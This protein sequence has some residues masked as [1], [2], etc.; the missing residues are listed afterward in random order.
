MKNAAITIRMLALV[1]AVLCPSLVQA[2][3]TAEDITVVFDDGQTHDIDYWINNESQYNSV[4]VE[5]RDSNSTGQFTTVNLLNNG[6][7][8]DQLFAC[9][10][11]R[12]NVSGGEI[13]GFL[14]ALDNSRIVCSDG[15]IS[16]GLIVCNR[17]RVT[18]SGGT[19][20]MGIRPLWTYDNSRVTI[21]GGRIGD[22]WICHNSRVTISGGWID[23]TIHVG[24]GYSKESVVKFIG[25]DFA[26]DGTAVGY[27]RIDTGGE[28]SIHGTLTGILAGGEDLDNEF[29][30]YGDSSILLAPEE[31][32]VVDIRPGSRPNPFNIKSKGVLSAAI[33][34][35]EYVNVRDIKPDS[36]RLE[37]VKP[38][39]SRYKDMATPVED[40][41][42]CNCA[43][44]GPDGYLDLALQF[45]TQE[46]A[47]AI[48][49][50]SDGDEQMLILTAEL[51][52]GTPVA[53]TDW[54]LIHSRSNP[55]F[56]KRISTKRR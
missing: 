53:G 17:S 23:G 20:G 44:E 21:S 3:E 52:D 55:R 1:L 50:V 12:V 24:R 2:E 47:E 15:I 11:S 33:L 31:T 40:G 51:S 54:V 10:K 13:G 36:I 46:V 37:G 25:S 41:Y 9:D 39:R 22:L 43:K 29:Y 38:I 8:E 7:I 6:Q 48:G 45:E 35:T 56:M 42:D 5:V 16:R 18:I 27:G 34:G 19:I 30:I 26:V 32:L 49:N 28:E 4:I 14:F